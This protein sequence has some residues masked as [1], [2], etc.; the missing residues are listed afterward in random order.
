MDDAIVGRAIASAMGREGGNDLPELSEIG[1]DD[2]ALRG[3]G[4]PGVNIGHVVTFFDELL[5]DQ[6]P[7]LSM[8]PVTVIG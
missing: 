4:P 1:P 3:G 7:T 6:K 5:Q 2:A 8:P